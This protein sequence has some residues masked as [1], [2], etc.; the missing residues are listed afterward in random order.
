MTRHNDNVRRGSRYS[1]DHRRLI[2]AVSE[3]LDG[4]LGVYRSDVLD[5]IEDRRG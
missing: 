3:L 5:K 1:R 2:V 4:D